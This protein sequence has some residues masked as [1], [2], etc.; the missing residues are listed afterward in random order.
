MGRT[1]RIYHRGLYA[2]HATHLRTWGPHPSIRFDHHRPQEP[3]YHDPDG[4]AVLYLAD[5]LRT[6]VRESALTSDARPLAPGGRPTVLVCERWQVAYVE[7]ERDEIVLQDLVQASP[8]LLGAPDDLGDGPHPRSMTQGWARAIYEDTPGGHRVAGI[9]YWSS[10]DRTEDDDRQGTNR[11]VWETSPPVRV[12][13]PGRGPGAREEYSIHH[14]TMRFLVS[15]LLRQDGLLLH[16]IPTSQC[17]PC[18][19][20]PPHA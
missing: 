18:Q 2:P 6:A 5:A 7:P 9:H 12:R 4:R 16:P 11:V 3:P 17:K 14:P 8:S 13:Q 15:R 20:A 19:D 10:K 1:Y